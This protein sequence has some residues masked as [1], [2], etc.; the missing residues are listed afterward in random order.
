MNF[1]WV[2]L[3]RLSESMAFAKAQLCCASLL[4]ITHAHDLSVGSQPKGA[5][6]GC[7]QNEAAVSW[8][9][10]CILLKSSRPGNE[11]NVGLD[12]SAGSLLG[13]DPK[14]FMDCLGCLSKIGFKLGLS[15]RERSFLG[16]LCATPAAEAENLVRRQRRPW[17]LAC[18]LLEARASSQTRTF[19]AQPPGSTKDVAP[20]PAIDKIVP[21]IRELL[22]R[23]NLRTQEP[24]L[25]TMMWL[26]VRNSLDRRPVDIL[27][28]SRD[29]LVNLG[30]ADLQQ[31]SL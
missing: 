3:V 7:Q 8:S 14:L 2:T 4:R 22:V 6:G 28:P 26:N 17:H 29:G 1:S 19:S 24:F 18:R 21:N 12:R 31:V 23:V 30:Y 13:W 27:L 15:C 20:F 16:Q 9:D 10:L 25:S 5:T 11:S